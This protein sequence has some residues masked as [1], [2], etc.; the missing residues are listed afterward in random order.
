MPKK[1]E[2]KKPE[3]SFKEL[4]E[5]RKLELRWEKFN[6]AHPMNALLLN[7]N[8]GNAAYCER[9]DMVACKRYHG[10]C[11]LCSTE[12]DPVVKCKIIT[13]PQMQTWVIKNHFIDHCCGNEHMM[14]VLSAVNELKKQF[15]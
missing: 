6:K 9:C 10:Y 13:N 4:K 12:F 5:M 2:E 15:D 7:W 14:K 1:D 3:Q 11:G 8:F